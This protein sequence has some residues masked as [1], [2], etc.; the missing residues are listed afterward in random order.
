[1]IDEDKIKEAEKNVRD[2]LEDGLIIKIET[3]RKEIYE[4]FVKNFI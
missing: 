4:T 3:Q 2:Y 1:M